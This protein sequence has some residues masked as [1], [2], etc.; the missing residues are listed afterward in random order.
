MIFDVTTYFEL[1]DFSYAG[2]KKEKLALGARDF[3][4]MEQYKNTEINAITDNCFTSLHLL[5]YKSCQKTFTECYEKGN[6]SRTNSF[7]LCVWCC[8]ILFVWL[9]IEKNFFFLAIGFAV[10]TL[11]LRHSRL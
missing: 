9:L 3:A 1:R 11:L 4:L 5:T 7:Y 6:L 10:S 2:N 8:I